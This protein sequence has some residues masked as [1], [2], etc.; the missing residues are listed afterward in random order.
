MGHHYVPQRYLRNFQD[1]HR[2]GF[3]WL[4]DKRGLVARPAAI[5]SVAQAKGFYSQE[6]EEQLARVVEKPGN[7]VIAKLLTGGDIDQ[8]ERLQ[9]AYYIGVMLKRVPRQR[10]KTS[11]MVPEVLDNVIENTRRELLALA[12]EM[13]ADPALVSRRLLE[14]EAVHAKYQN[15]PPQSVLNQVNEPWPTERVVRSIFE[16]SWRVVT[17]TGP[18]KFITSDNPAYFFEGLGLGNADSEL[19]FPLSLTHALHGSWQGPHRSLRFLQ[20]NQ[21]VVRELN[22]RQ[23]SGAERLVFYHQHAQWLI[24]ILPKKDPYL[25]RIGW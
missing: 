24:D 17:T 22:R 8:V 6:T 2:E 15:E 10:R 20:V 19:C 13:Q 18:Q 7:R 23:A 25:S 16:M 21:R 14:I 12:G 9:L 11:E 3:L 5:K 1:P 4:H